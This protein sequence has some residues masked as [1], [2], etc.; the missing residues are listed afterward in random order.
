MNYVLPEEEKQ[1]LS[2][3]LDEHIPVKLN[4]N[5]I[6]IEFECFHYKVMQHTGHLRQN[7]QDQ[8]KSKI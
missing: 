5:K 6:Q 1:A 3:S 4:E 8:L 7:E 2:Y